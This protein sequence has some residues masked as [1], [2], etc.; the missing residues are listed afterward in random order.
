M[1]GGEFLR[2]PQR[3]ILSMHPHTFWVSNLRHFG[4]SFQQS[5]ASTVPSCSGH[6][7]LWKKVKTLERTGSDYGTS[8]GLEPCE[9]LQESL[10]QVEQRAH[11]RAENRPQELEALSLQNSFF[12]TCHFCDLLFVFQI[13]LTFN[14][15]GSDSLLSE[16][17]HVPDPLL[18]LFHEVLGF[19]M[20]LPCL[21]C[22]SFSTKTTDM[23][24]LLI[25]ALII[26]FKG[27]WVGNGRE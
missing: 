24:K 19:Q 2:S 27:K 14:L 20:H 11:G 10:A 25:F 8:T 7:G 18:I 13:F 16:H 4:S 5:W 23:S 3:Q 9:T 21:V 12:S 15:T 22:K 17:S 6:S 1:W 26:P